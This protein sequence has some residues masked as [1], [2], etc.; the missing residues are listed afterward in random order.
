MFGPWRGGRGAHHR[1]LAVSAQI[2]EESPAPASGT[3]R[4]PQNLKNSRATRRR[5]LSRPKVENVP[6]L[7]RR[8]C[9]RGSFRRKRPGPTRTTPMRKSRRRRRRRRGALDLVG[10]SLPRS[11]ADEARASTRPRAGDATRQPPSVTSGR[12]LHGRYQLVR[13]HDHVATPGAARRAPARSTRG[14]PET[15]LPR[16]I[17][18][19]RVLKAQSDPW[20]RRLRPGD[21]CARPMTSGV[22]LDTARDRDV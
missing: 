1:D 7:R 10:A 19:R 8:T 20:A 17:C 6:S 11:P 22:G 9:A 13:Q 12:L 18:G 3:A 14:L 5:R 21:G 4:V 16:I 15:R 2:A